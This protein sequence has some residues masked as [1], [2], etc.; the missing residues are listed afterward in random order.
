MVLPEDLEAFQWIRSNTSRDACFLVNGFLAFRN[1]TVVGSD[2]GWWLPFFTQRKNNVPP[3]LYAREKLS[4]AVDR[5][6]L[7]RIIHD[8]EAS[9][10]DPEAMR[11]V[12][13]REGIMY[14]F[15]GEKRGSVGYNQEPLVQE[16]WL[17]N[18]PDFTLVFQAGKAQ[19]WKF[20]QDFSP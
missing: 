2:A 10:G 16:S 1:S 19:V 12:F 6:G 13:C 15:L 7:K 11:A 4:P 14:V 20:N 17:R 9:H 8:I 5:E 3:V 18:N